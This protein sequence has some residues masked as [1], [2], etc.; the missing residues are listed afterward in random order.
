[1]NGF[2]TV[3]RE[4]REQLERSEKNR[5]SG[6]EHFYDVPKARSAARDEGCDICRQNYEEP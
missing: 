2:F 5:E 4:L 3:Y 1:M 6:K